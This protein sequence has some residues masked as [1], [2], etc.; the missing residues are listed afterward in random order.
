MSVVHRLSRLCCSLFIFYFL[1]GGHIFGLWLRVVSIWEVSFPNKILKTL[2]CSGSTYWP[3]A[4][5]LHT[6]GVWF[7][8]FLSTLSENTSRTSKVLL[9]T[10]RLASVLPIAP[11]RKTTGPIQVQDTQSFFGLLPAPCLRSGNMCCRQAA[12]SRWLL[13]KSA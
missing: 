8:D 4:P 5:A 1:F 10:A 13:D 7:N 12:W 6:S 2:S 9:E 11:P 3:P